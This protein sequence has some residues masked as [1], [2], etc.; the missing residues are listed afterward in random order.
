MTSD[1]RNNLSQ[2]FSG[3]KSLNAKF[4]NEEVKEIRRLYST[5]KYTQT[6]LSRTYNTS[7]FTISEIMRYKRYKLA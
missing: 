5:G 4:S 3:E 1:A 7:T 2:V 6:E